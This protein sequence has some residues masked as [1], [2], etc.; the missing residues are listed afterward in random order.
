MPT[1]TP[2]PATFTPQGPA[3]RRLPGSAARLSTSFSLNPN[4]SSYSDVSVLSP[5]RGRA[6]FL[7]SAEQG[8]MSMSQVSPARTPLRRGTANS[9]LGRWTRG[10][11][12]TA[13]SSRSRLCDTSHTSLSAS[14]D[15]EDELDELEGDARA[16]MIASMRTWRNDAAIHNLYE[17]AA[18]WADKILSLTGE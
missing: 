4:D 13:T 18:F 14:A 17:T 5:S 7:S 6:A 9:V 11:P 15:A 2:P 16:G 8:N 3:R 10:V 12:G 1:H